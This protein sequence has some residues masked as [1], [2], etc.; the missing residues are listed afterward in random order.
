MRTQLVAIFFF[1][2]GS[3]GAQKYDLFEVDGGQLVWRNIYEYPTHGDSLKAAL[4]K[5]LY[6]TSFIKKVSFNGKEFR[7]EIDNYQIDCKHYG[8][9]FLNTPRIYWDGK[10]R[11]KFIVQMVDNYYRVTVYALH[12]ETKKDPFTF[13]RNPGPRKGYY[14]KEV[15]HKDKSGFKQ[16]AL[17]DMALLSLSLKNNFDWAPISPPRLPD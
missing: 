15:M 14:S 9:T 5:M 13:H 7:G 4:E 12:F 1:V 11:G 6:G 3:L 10:W 2:C 8:R 16:A 17:A